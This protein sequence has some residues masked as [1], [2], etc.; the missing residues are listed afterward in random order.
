FEDP[1]NLSI[2]VTFTTSNG[3]VCIIGFEMWIYLLLANE[4]RLPNQ[5]DYPSDI[6][7]K[8]N[9]SNIL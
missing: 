9:K 4:N 5:N 6:K 8:A 3:F 7:G 1:Q 2:D